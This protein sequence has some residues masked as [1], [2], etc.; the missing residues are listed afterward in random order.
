MPSLYVALYLSAPDGAEL[1]DATRMIRVMVVMGVLASCLGAGPAHPAAAI[2]APAVSSLTPVNAWLTEVVT[3]GTHAFAIAPHDNVVHVL[4]L[5]DGTLEAP[6]P[7]GTSPAGLDLSGDGSQ[8]YVANA[9]SNDVSVVD[10]ALRREVRR[11]PVP[12]LQ[13]TGRPTSIAVAS[14]GTALLSRVPDG[15]SPGFPRLLSIDLATGAMRERTD[16]LNPS[17]PYVI[18]L[19]A[20]GDRSTIGIADQFGLGAVSL[21]TAA[22]DSFSS[23]KFV[24]DASF[25]AM[26]GTGSKVLVGPDTLVLD[27]ALVLRATIPGS[28][29]AS[30]TRVADLAVGASG[31]TAYRLRGGVIEVVDLSR[32][33][34]T[35]A[36]VL[37]EAATFERGR[38]TL[39]ADGTTLVALT[40]SGFAVVPVSAAIARSCTPPPA[41]AGVVQVCG[42][43]LADMVT[44]NRG[45]AYVSNPTRNQ[46]EVVSLT[47]RRVEASIPVGSQPTSLDLSPDG[48]TLYVVNSGAEEVSVV[49]VVQRRE[50]RRITVPVRAWGDGP[51]RLLSLAVAGNGK[52]LLT[53]R[54]LTSGFGVQLLQIDLATGTVTPRTD[55]P[56]AAQYA[57][58]SAD[59]SRIGFVPGT[60]NGVVFA[61]HAVTDAFTTGKDVSGS[62]SQV[63]LDGDG[64]EMLVG[65]GAVGWEP[66]IYRLDRDLVRR[67]TID[68]H[69]RLGM[70]VNPAGTRIV[71]V[72]SVSAVVSDLERAVDL[73]L[74]PLPERLP[75]AP[76]ALV[77]TPDESAVAVL[78]TSGVSFV[79]IS[80]GTPLGTC[81]PLAPVSGL[82][83]VCGQL[84]DVVTAGGKAYVTN[85]THNRVEVISLADGMLEA[86]IL[87][88]SRPQGLDFSADGRLL[89]VALAGAEEVSVVDVAQG[90]ELR[91]VTIRSVGYNDRP[92]SIAVASSGIALVTTS[93]AGS[94]YGGTMH[95]IDLATGTPSPRSE[96]GWI[97]DDT[98]MRAS[99]DRSRVLVVASDSGGEVDVY[100]SESDSFGPGRHLRDYLSFAALDGT[101]TR[102]LFDNGV[103]VDREQGVIGDVTGGGKGVAV[104]WEGTTGYRV[105]DRS[106]DL[107]DMATQTVARTLP[108]P[109]SVAPARGAIALS[110][111]EKSLVVLTA[112]GVSLVPVVPASPSTPYTVW[113]QPG[114]APLDG[115][116]T[117]IAIT[118]EPQALAGQL[119]PSH[120]FG[121]YFSFAKSGVT[122]AVALVKQPA[123]KFAV[124][125]IAE[126]GRPLR[127]AT[128]PF[129]WRGG[130][131]YF[132]FVYQVSPGTWGAWV[133]DHASPT[134]V[135]IGSFSLPL[136]WGGLSTTTVTVSAWAGGA[137][138]SCGTYPLADV[139][140]YPPLGLVGATAS[141]AT[142]TAT[143]QTPGACA[144]RTSLEH[145]LWARHRVGAGA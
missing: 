68:A 6:I 142:L 7:V 97:T 59:H 19:R 31:G 123:G 116:G 84:A 20:S 56:G 103:V 92:T 80:G 111:D 37:P 73:R 90:R 124:F 75:E 2:V 25:L 48:N 100:E 26:D 86:P 4:S 119:A 101:G 76:A 50:A 5:V 136:A 87:V 77:F 16:W 94:G 38:L 61:Y 132:L 40:V 118:D 121:H 78:S 117:W 141:Y 24:G 138:P 70:T 66:G 129:E 36:I 44:D 49:D 12:P 102:A 115:T 41:P 126:P 131:F 11:L 89:Y 122:G 9:G 144:A 114:T 14:T 8:L 98:I 30:G 137:G 45:R 17:P 120:L 47:G 42:A 58:S 88:G 22:T 130:G 35:A 67:G 99:G 54:S 57:R 33:L 91:R 71:S 51:E 134:P 34:V 83:A 113:T 69:P 108:L 133:Y 1:M 109:E 46:I 143:A 60:S 10:V 85:A 127:S 13:R 21:Y 110:A 145:N 62:L 3:T 112:H 140:Y 93:H 15:T 43:P 65:P 64:S 29:D 32:A 95:Q 39:T 106:V 55:A 23:R 125:A 28:A 82:T 79:S 128:V 81:A 105:Q 27:R 52:A 139:M 107:I 135:P 63:A 72:S 104:D 74:V 53:T 18:R 96:I